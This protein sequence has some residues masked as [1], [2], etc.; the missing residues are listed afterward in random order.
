M[1]KKVLLSLSFVVA[2][3]G[4]GVMLVGVSSRREKQ[5]KTSQGVRLSSRRKNRRDEAKERRK[6]IKDN[7][8]GQQAT[9]N[10]PKLIDDMY[11]IEIIE[12]CNFLRQRQVNFAN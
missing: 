10:H 2:I 3:C 7:D 9:H 6:Q 1:R 5:T 4:M 11:K 8:N 12:F